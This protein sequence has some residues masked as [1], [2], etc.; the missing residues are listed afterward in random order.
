MASL[1]GHYQH[2]RNENLDEYFKSVGV[3]YIPRK[4]MTM[5]SPRLEI[6]KTEDDKW[7]IR[8][9]TM[10]RTVVLIFRIGEEFEES[11]PGGVTL[12][13]VATLDEDGSITIHSEGPNETKVTRKYELK[14]DQIIL[15]MT[16][17]KSG[18][19]AKRYFK[20]VPA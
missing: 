6:E 12:K 7:T 4:M 15:T 18:T 19:S 1:S 9:I 3:P 14:D 13:N 5:T 8:S 20:K 16:H 10:M 2:E 17:E 11:M